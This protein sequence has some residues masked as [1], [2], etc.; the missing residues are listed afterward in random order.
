M[1]LDTYTFFL[2][3]LSGF[4][5]VWSFRRFSKTTRE[6][7]DFEYLGFSAFWGTFIL[8]R[9]ILIAENSSG[10]DMSKMYLMMDKSPHIA[11][12]TFSFYGLIFG[13]VTGLVI[14]FWR[15]KIPILILS[16]K[17]TIN[18]LKRKYYTNKKKISLIVTV[19]IFQQCL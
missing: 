16:M 17:N 2:V 4:M 11:G 19:T 13:S 5:F 7:S 14:R 3:I 18:V 15:N 8:T 6:I 1:S 9:I 12:A 10:Y